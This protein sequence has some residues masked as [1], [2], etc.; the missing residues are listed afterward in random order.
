MALEHRELSG[1]PDG[2]I[3]LDGRRLEEYI[4]V[5]DLPTNPRKLAV[6]E[7]HYEEMRFAELTGDWIMGGCTFPEEDEAPIMR[8]QHVCPGPGLI[9]ECRLRI[10]QF[11]EH[12]RKIGGFADSFEKLKETLVAIRRDRAENRKR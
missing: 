8:Y 2:M 11:D 1:E 4:E 5:P 3:T 10:D 6:C 12:G 7:Q 9:R